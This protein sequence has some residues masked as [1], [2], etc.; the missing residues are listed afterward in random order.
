M[1]GKYETY[2]SDIIVLYHV[3]LVAVMFYTFFFFF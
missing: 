1:L 2:I 3:C